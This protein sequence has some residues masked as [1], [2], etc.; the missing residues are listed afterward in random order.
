[1][2]NDMQPSMAMAPANQLFAMQALQERLAAQD[3]M[4]FADN[5][6]HQQLLHSATTSCIIL[7]QA[8]FC[9]PV[10]SV[11]VLYT[12]YA[13]ISPAGCPCVSSGSANN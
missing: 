12:Y 1:M 6:V 7:L 5:V 10:P 13:S 4:L 3:E 8:P 2:L 11:P 9:R